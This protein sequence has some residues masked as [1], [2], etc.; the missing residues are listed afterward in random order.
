[1]RRVEKEISLSYKFSHPAVIDTVCYGGK[2]LEIARE[3]RN[4]IVLDNHS[5]QH[6]FDLLRKCSIEDALA[7]SKCS[8]EDANVV[9]MQL[10]ARHFEK[11]VRYQRLSPVMQ[12]YLTNGCNMHCPHC[13]MYAGNYC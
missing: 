6:F 9:V 7:V 5:Q 4:W 12:L 11:R 8:D 3:E 10:V 13:Y 1:M 2:I